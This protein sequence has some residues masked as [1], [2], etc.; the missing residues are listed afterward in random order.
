MAKPGKVSLSLTRQELHR[1]AGGR[2]SWG[3]QN[4]E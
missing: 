2:A 1:D 4:D 3:R